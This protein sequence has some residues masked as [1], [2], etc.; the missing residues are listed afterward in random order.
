MK[1][2]ND[3]LKKRFSEIGCQSDTNNPL[4]IAIFFHPSSLATWYATE[5]DPETNI[6]Y[7]YVTGLAEDE[8]GNFSIDEM[9]AFKQ[10]V[11][12]N[13][14]GALLQ[15]NVHIERDL[16]FNETRFKELNL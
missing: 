11:F 9:E 16:H 8:W 3:A 7:G 2:I 4:V 13:I 5:Y 14:E 6:C 10:E 12:L 1:L 15:G